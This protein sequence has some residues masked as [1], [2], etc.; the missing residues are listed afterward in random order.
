MA[1]GFAFDEGA[2]AGAEVQVNCREISGALDQSSTVHP[3][4]T[5][6]SDDVH[7]GK[8]IPSPRQS[9]LGPGGASR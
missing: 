2:V 4:L 5:P 9:F 1:A 8:C 7:G 3:A 6:A